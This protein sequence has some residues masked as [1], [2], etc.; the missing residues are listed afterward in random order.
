M[1]KTVVGGVVFIGAAAVTSRILQHKQIT[2][3]IVGSFVLMLMLSIL[4]FFGGAGNTLASALVSVAV[5]VTIVD[6][7]P[8]QAILQAIGAKK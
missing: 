6:V 4:E 3:V 1:N 5:L 8:W 2:P 7:L